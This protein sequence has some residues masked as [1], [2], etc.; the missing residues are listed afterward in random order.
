MLLIFID[1]L[2]FSFKYDRLFTSKSNV[3]HQNAVVIWKLDVGDTILNFRWYYIWW[4]YGRNLETLSWLILV[5]YKHGQSLILLTLWKC[6]FQDK[7]KMS[8][9][10]GPK[11]PKRQCWEL[12]S[13]STS[14]PRVH[15]SIGKC[16]ECDLQSGLVRKNKLMTG[17]GSKINYF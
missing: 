13:T 12:Q 10:G 5:N 4:W 9:P 1:W 2:W 7:K 6:V 8:G 14:G 16:Q 3:F 11:A 17:K 15:N